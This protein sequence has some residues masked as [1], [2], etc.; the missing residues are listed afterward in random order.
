MSNALAASPGVKA[1][2]L[3]LLALALLVPLLQVRFLVQERQARAQEAEATIARQWGQAQLLAPAYLSVAAAGAATA[4]GGFQPRTEARILLPDRIEV[5]GE[6][7]TEVRARGMFRVPVYVAQLRVKARFDAAEVAA[8]RALAAD[9]ARL[10]LDLALGDPRGIQVLGMLQANGAPQR[11]SVTGP[12][13]GG[14]RAFGID[15]PAGSDAIEVE[16]A[17]ALAGVGELRILPLA[18]TNQVDLRGDWGDPAFI[19]A[20]LP[21]SRSIEPGAFS[22]S[23]QVPEFSRDFAQQGALADY[24]ATLLDASAFGVRLY[25]PAGLYQQ[26]ERSAKYGVLMVALL[27]V[28]LFLFE[29][30]AGLRL[31]PLQ[32]LL[33]GL[34]L[35]TFYLLLLALSEHVGFAGAYGISAGAAVALVGAYAA[36]VLG[37]RRRALALAA[38]Q[39]GA[40]GVFYVLVRSEDYALLMGATVLFAA[41][42]ALMWLTRRTDWHALGRPAAAPRPTRDGG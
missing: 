8:L 10:R 31:H 39:A 30:L 4:E 13:P 41:L 12:G 22:A 35:A 15:L 2:L 9:P 21:A 17:L 29:V 26:N 27:F 42:A 40:Y 23:W 38:L 5:G 7:R 18:R 25:Q 14:L 20:F 1:L 33:V 37:S 36:A 24:D 32:Y 3:G 19:G 16:Y 34:A 6:L 11:A 28:A